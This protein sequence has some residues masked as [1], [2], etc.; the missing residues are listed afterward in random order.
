MKPSFD[1]GDT[2]RCINEGNTSL[3]KGS[4]YTVSRVYKASTGWYVNL[5]EIKI[6]HNYSV[7]RFVLSHCSLENE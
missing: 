2:V 4:L 6:E 3:V 7:N 1:I 5:E